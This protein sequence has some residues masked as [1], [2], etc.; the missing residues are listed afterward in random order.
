ML[1]P[2]FG[3]RAEPF[4]LRSAP[5]LFCPTRPFEAAYQ[6][7]AGA[8]A[9]GHRLILLAGESGVGKTTLLR[10]VSAQFEADGAGVFSLACTNA[11]SFNLLQACCDLAQ[12]AS[13]PMSTGTLGPS[14]SFQPN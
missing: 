11:S 5:E 14:N 3:L 8:V 6:A 1:A 9:S 4:E 12:L 2:Y 10:R 13:A 7:V